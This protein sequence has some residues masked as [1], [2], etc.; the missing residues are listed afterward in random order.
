MQDK[1]NNKNNNNNVQYY[2]DNRADRKEREG[3]ERERE[4][5]VS[6]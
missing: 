3:E 4:I 6:L 2:I 1:N 5:I